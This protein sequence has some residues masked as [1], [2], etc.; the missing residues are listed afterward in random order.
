[1]CD[2][3]GEDKLQ[4]T[5][6]YFVFNENLSFGSKRT[7]GGDP[8]RVRVRAQSLRIRAGG[9]ASVRVRRRRSGCPAL[10]VYGQRKDTATRI[11]PR[12]P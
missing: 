6:G 10:I 1:M 11:A 12:V 3:E 8:E 7:K 5:C 4:P 9:N 2:E